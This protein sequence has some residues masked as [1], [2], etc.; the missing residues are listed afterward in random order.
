[1]HSRNEQTAL[2]KMKK[3]INYADFLVFDNFKVN[4]VTYLQL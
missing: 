3:D 1:M 4:G 2:E